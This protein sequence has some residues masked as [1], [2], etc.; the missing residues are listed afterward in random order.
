MKVFAENLI[1]NEAISRIEGAL[2]RYAPS[3]VE[4]VTNEKEADLVI[5]YAFS[6]RRK[7]DKR[8]KWILERG[9]S[10]AI[11]QI[12]VRATPCPQV[13]D[14]IEMW[15][16]AN[17]VWSYLNLYAYCL[18]E[19]QMMDFTFYHSPLGVDTEVFKESKQDRTYKIVVGNSRDETVVQCEQAAGGRV[20]HLGTGVSDKQ[21]AKAYSQSEYVSGLRRKE[22]FEMPVIEGLMCGARPICYDRPHYRHWFGDLVEYIK[23]DVDVEESLMKLFS[24]KPRKVT[25]DEK[26]LVKE[27]FNWRTII[28]AFWEIV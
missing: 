22:G 10:F 2:K 19:G 9:Q 21:L 5:I 28:E 23:E 18:E 12:A 7:V 24:K 13:S 27:F 25:D 3:D 14:W 26:S 4:F 6:Q 16:K 8:I 20:F 15:R 11:M 1:T 17:V